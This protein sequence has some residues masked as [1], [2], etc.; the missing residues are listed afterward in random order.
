VASRRGMHGVSAKTPPPP[1]LVHGYA[2]DSAK[3][4]CTAG[5]HM[6]MYPKW[7][8]KY[9]FGKITRKLIFIIFPR[10]YKKINK[11]PKKIKT[12]N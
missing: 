1:P 5:T 2:P 9:I 11:Y 7:T 6:V 8:K 3:G 12:N 10:K 4:D